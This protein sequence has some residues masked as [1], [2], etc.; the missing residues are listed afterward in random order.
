MNK[1]TNQIEDIF[2]EAF[3]NYEVDAGSNA[4]QAI[5]SKMAAES[6]AAS[7]AS[8]ASTTT[9]ATSS[10]WLATAIVATLIS[11]TAVG[12]Y[13]FFN[14]TAEKIKDKEPQIERNENIEQFETINNQTE[15]QSE[16][17]IV[18]AEDVQQESNTKSNQS[19]PSNKPTIQSENSIQ[20]TESTAI[21][22][23]EANSAPTESNLKSPSEEEVQSNEST[24][25]TENRHSESTYEQPNNQSTI[26]SSKQETVPVDQL[27]KEAA[28]ETND[29]KV[30]SNSS[31]SSV[32]N[33]I[34]EVNKVETPDF[35]RIP[36][37]FSPDQDGTNDEF[38]VEIE[39]I[40]KFH[41][42]IFNKSG[43][44]VFEAYDINENWKG[45]LP[46]G[47]I[48][49]VGYYAYQITVHKEGKAYKKNGGIFLSSNK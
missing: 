9:A 10:S 25:A 47:S 43:K 16:K 20:K 23:N 31:T 34:K 46:N 11:A 22:E 17:A 39:N 3:E 26:A 12:G 38:V 42:Q 24:D 45:D 7:S 37:V 2:R 8:A 6:A 1:E 19:N 14:D 18:N 5:K 33:D 41:I 48:A 44:M 36:N 29:E 35:S 4:W 28:V 30:N 13:F 21:A 32:S 40:D 49:P 27:A 15:K